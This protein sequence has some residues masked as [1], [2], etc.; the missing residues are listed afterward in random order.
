[1]SFNTY[2]F[3]LVFL[4]VSVAGYHILN[5]R[6]QFDISKCFLLILSILFIVQASWQGTIATILLVLINY[7]IVDFSYK[8]RFKKAMMI[9]GIILNVLSLCFFKYLGIF[10]IHDP[11]DNSIVGGNEIISKLYNFSNLIIPLGISFITFSQ[12]SFLIDE[13]REYE[14]V[15]FIDYAVYVLYFPKVTMGPI[16]LSK[17]FIKNLNESVRKD[18][19]FDNI[20][21]GLYAFSFGLAKKVL[22]ADLLAGYVSYAYDYTPILGMTNAWLA[23]LAY[24]LQIY[25]DFS[26]FCDMANGISLMMNIELPINFNSP[27]R[28]LSIGEFWDRWHITLTKFFTKYIYIPLGG[29]RKGTIRTYINI[30]IVFLIS[31]IWHSNTINFVIWG[32]IHGV[33]SSISRAIKPIEDKIPKFIRWTVTFIC[34]NIAWVYFRAPSLGAANLM[35]KE[36]F[37]FKFIP[38][39]ANF[40][41]YA[42]P[43]ELELVPWLVNKFTKI[44][45]TY[46]FSAFVNV[47]VVA[48]S[49]FASVKMKN[50][51]ERIDEF[52]ATK[53]TMIIC[54]VL[55]V[56]SVLSLSEVS[57]FIYVNF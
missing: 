43:K 20:A 48:F 12:I 18:T 23:V 21:K 51:K 13:Y 38:I 35:I 46:Y 44:K 22:L 9:I 34:I 45:S 50:T 4:P 55:L 10:M 42:F 16:A 19:D 6:K 54:V 14:E 52:N 33:L 27:Y 25:F 32:L 2:F 24:T 31:G 56:W 17:D 29:S 40:A 30:M 26:G 28:S 11:L 39:D 37:S 5:K 41:T 8:T 49:L 7:L 47:F 53:K 1:M 57:G 15:S 3:V 36:L